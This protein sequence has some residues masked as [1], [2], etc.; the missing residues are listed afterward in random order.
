[1]LQEEKLDIT[2]VRLETS[3]TELLAQLAQH[4][5][6]SGASA[7]NSTKLLHLHPNKTTM[8]HK[9]YEMNRGAVLNFFSK[10]VQGRMAFDNVFII[11]CMLNF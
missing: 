2:G 9:L 4:I 5:G 11:Y 1:V 8:V 6:M 10:T 3:P 7:Q